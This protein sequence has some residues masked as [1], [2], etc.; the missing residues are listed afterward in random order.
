MNQTKTVGQTYGIAFSN[1]IDRIVL[2]L[3]ASIYEDSCL[4]RKSIRLIVLDFSMEQGDEATIAMYGF[5]RYIQTSDKSNNEK[6]IAMR[7]TLS[8]DIHERKD[9]WMLPRSSGYKEFAHH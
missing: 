6:L 2:A 3:E 7:E 5:I 9:K 1:M 8:H 4:D